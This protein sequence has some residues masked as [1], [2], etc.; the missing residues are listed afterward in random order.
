MRR[1]V[2]VKKKYSYYVE[3]RIKGVLLLL[4]IGKNESSKFEKA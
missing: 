2:V 1:A 3:K 4:K